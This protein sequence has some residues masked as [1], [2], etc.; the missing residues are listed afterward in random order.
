[1]VPKNL[2]VLIYAH[3]GKE[4]IIMSISILPRTL[5]NNTYATNFDLQ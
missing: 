5:N 1:M 4:V 2:A 3:R